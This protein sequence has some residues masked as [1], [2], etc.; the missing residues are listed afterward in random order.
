MKNKKIEVQLAILILLSLTLYK[1]NPVY[2][3]ELSKEFLVKGRTDGIG[4]YFEIKNSEYL[5][6]ILKS[7][8]EIKVVLESAKKTIRIKIEKVNEVS[9]FVNLTIEGLEPNKTYYKYQNSYKNEV[10]FTSDDNGVFNWS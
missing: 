6:V 10:I 8:R 2:G 9:S 1:V 4:R 7:D 3:N 5:D